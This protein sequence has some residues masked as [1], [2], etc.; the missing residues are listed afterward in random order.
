MN[1]VQF[2]PMPIFPNYLQP[3]L[4][5]VV[6]SELVQLSQDLHGQR[7]GEADRVEWPSLAIGFLRQKA[8]D[9]ADNPRQADCCKLSQRC[10]VLSRWGQLPCARAGTSAGQ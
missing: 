10:A 5:Q 4:L 9:E 8:T 1:G 3:P 7:G 6:L 2:Q